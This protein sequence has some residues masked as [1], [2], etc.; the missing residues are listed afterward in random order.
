MENVIATYFYKE[1]ESINSSY[2]NISTNNKDQIYW[3]TVYLFYL[4]SV[5]FNKTARH[6]FFTNIKNFPYRDSLEALG[7]D[8][9]DDL[10]NSNLGSGKWASVKFFF[11]VINYIT[12]NEE[13]DNDCY[14]ALFDTDCIAVNKFNFDELKSDN[15]GYVVGV[16]N[17]E[18]YNFHGKSLKELADIYK[19]IFN[20]SI[21]ISD[22][23]GG[24]FFCFKK[25][26]KNNIF[27]YFEC[28]LQSKYNESIKT[29]EQILSMVNSDFPLGQH[30][31][32]IK[33]VW[34]TPK[35]FNLKSQDINDFYFLHL[36]SEKDNVTNDLL[37]L[38]KSGDFDGDFTRTLL[39]KPHK[40]WL[41]KIKLKILKNFWGTK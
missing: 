12:I 4:T 25:S 26:D 35:C 37:N 27:E 11:D 1:D 3:N 20:R 22:K 2:A 30:T 14:Y 23:V 34:T 29:E 13:F 5:F 7:V 28:I 40:L 16:E 6:C 38:F 39:S 32:L 15:Y 9:Y 21:V 17:K 8:I 31:K 33:R 19:S 18:D 41:E 36:P 24:E 10:T